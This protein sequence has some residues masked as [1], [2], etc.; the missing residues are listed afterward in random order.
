MAEL[1]LRQSLRLQHQLVITP[2]LQQAIKLL[3]LGRLELSLKVRE[4]LDMNPVLEELP[5]QTQQEELKEGEPSTEPEVDWERIVE[6]YE[7][8]PQAVRETGGEDRPT[9]EA[10]LTRSSTLAEHLA[11][12]LRLARFSEEEEAIG[13]LIVGNVTEDGYLDASLEEIAAQAGRPREAV[14]GVLRRIQQFDPPGVAAR[15]LQECLLLQ[16]AHLGYA[17]TL[18]ERLVREFLPNLQKHD[19][20]G[21]SRAVGLPLEDIRAALRVVE[22]LDPKPGRLLGEGETQYVV[23]DVYIRKVG[24]DYK[25]FLNDDGLPKLRISSYYQRLLRQTGTADA[26]AKE[27]LRERMRSALWLIKS[28]HQRQR[29]IYRVAESI[30]RFQRAFLDRGLAHLRPLVLKDVADD[31]GVHESTVSRVT[32]NKYAHTPRGIFE[33]K[34]FFNPG[35]PKAGGEAMASESVKNILREMIEKEPSGTPLSDH[36]LTARLRA[37]GLDIA[38]RT[39]TKYRQ[40]LGLG[41]S[42]ERKRKG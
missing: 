34:F 20:E 3:Q 8:P 29:T 4:E 1:G 9:F 26:G 24:E 38:R 36:E 19:L 11:W 17:G 40:L 30:V 32:N 39:V 33:L 6:E 5:E 31:V 15:D 41:S 12:Q 10:F 16:V 7:P 22:S 2:Q 42:S 13:A 21:V 18:V 35:I 14:E 25:V 27:Y 37:E 28:L 23:P